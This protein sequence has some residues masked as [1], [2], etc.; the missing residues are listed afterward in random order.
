VIAK[1]RQKTSK[2]GQAS[3][4][5]IRQRTVQIATK[6]RQSPRFEVRG[7]AASG[8]ATGLEWEKLGDFI[9]PAFQVVRVS[10]GFS[11]GS[12]ATVLRQLTKRRISASYISKIERARGNMSWQRLGLLC[13]IVGCR[14]SEVVK[15]AEDMMV[16]LQKP[17]HELI[18]NVLDEAK[19]RMAGGD[20]SA[21]E[22]EVLLAVQA[23][24]KRR[25]AR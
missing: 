19:K 15:A 24:M 9:G 5:A 13:R 2:N 12:L 14:P 16:D 1:L 18:Q 17:Q 7:P 20:V 25:L 11:Q 6:H 4:F 23:E 21:V 10:R 3:A 22:K 8:G